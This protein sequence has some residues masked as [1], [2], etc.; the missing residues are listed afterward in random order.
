[1]RMVYEVAKVVDIP[2]IGMG[3]ICSGADAVEFIMAGA[4]AVMVGTAIS[5]T[6]G[7]VPRLPPKLSSL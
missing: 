6:L 5:P 3:G 7:L 1:M 4:S 2:V